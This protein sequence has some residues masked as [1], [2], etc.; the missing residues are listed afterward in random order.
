MQPAITGLKAGR[1]ERWR[2]VH[3]G[4]REAVFFTIYP[5]KAGAP[6]FRKVPAADQAAW[7]NKYLSL[8]HI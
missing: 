8:I 4:V 7:M 6:D 3:G 2:L 1:F 5:Q